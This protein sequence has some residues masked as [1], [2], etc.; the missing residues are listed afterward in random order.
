VFDLPP[1]CSASIRSKPRGRQSSAGQTNST[2]SHEQQA[3]GGTAVAW[4]LADHAMRLTLEELA[5]RLDLARS[6][7]LPTK[8]PV[9]NG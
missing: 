3:A 9:N 6:A 4:R 8:S 7:D 5:E 1:T 2:G